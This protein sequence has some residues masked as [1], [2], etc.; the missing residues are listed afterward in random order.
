MKISKPSS[1]LLQSI[2]GSII[3]KSAIFDVAGATLGILVGWNQGKFSCLG[4]FIGDF[5][6]TAHF[7]DPTSG[8]KWSITSIYGPT[9]RTRSSSFW[10]ELHRSLKSL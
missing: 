3:D 2:G 6:V 9:D 10:D 8:F 1:R 4:T 5:S 7:L